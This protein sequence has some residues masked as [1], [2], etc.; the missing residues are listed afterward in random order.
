MKLIRLVLVLLWVVAL[1]HAHVAHAQRS[2]A[3]ALAA[4]RLRATTEATA[5]V[6]PPTSAQ[7]ALQTM[8]AAADVV[9]QGE[10]TEIRRH[11]GFV[12]IAFRVDESVRGIA[13]GDTFTLREWSGLWNDH[14][15]YTVG[16]RK[17]M[18]LHAASAAGLASPVAGTDGAIPVAGDNVSGTVDLRWIAARALRQTGTQSTTQGIRNTADV[19]GMQLA[20]AGTTDATSAAMQHADRSV[21]MDLLHA[22]QKKVVIAQ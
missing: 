13:A 15:R 4:A 12:E 21:V 7:D 2:L 14:A 8:F 16:E 11:E 6:Q 5:A 9:F 17:L 18:L 20:A 22:W 19:S 1:S 3:D 10:V